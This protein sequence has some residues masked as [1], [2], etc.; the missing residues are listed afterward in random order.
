MNYLAA[1]KAVWGPDYGRGQLARAGQRHP[2][3][4]EVP[5]VRERVEA[6]CDLGNVA[7]RNAGRSQSADDLVAIGISEC[8]EFVE[9]FDGLLSEHDR[10]LRGLGDPDK[11]EPPG[12]LGGRPRP[13]VH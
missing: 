4:L 12:K 2:G 5:K 7:G 8:G 10:D 11:L 6:A 9:R 13:L 3:C 1:D